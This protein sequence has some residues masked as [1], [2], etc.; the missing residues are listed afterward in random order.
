MEWIS[1]KDRLPKPRQLVLA[2]LNKPCDRFNAPYKEQVLILWR[3][4]HNYI[5]IG[6]TVKWER[7]FSGETVD[8]NDSVTHWMPIPQLPNN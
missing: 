8:Y 4:E 2:V 5:D 1:V 3:S 7:P 6:Y